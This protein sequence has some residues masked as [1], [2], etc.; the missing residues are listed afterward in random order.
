MVNKNLLKAKI[1]ENGLSIEEVYTRMG[2]TKRQWYARI[3]KGEFNST[4]IVKLCEILNISDPVP[5]FLAK[6]KIK[7]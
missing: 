2:L 5:I 3:S 7:K 1:C 4:E 6:N